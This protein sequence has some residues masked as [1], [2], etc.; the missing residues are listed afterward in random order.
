VNA[1]VLWDIDRTLLTIE[2]VSKDIYAAAFWKVTGQDL[3]D[4]PAMG[5]RT[6]RDLIAAVLAAHGF[7][8]TAQRLDD[9]Y[10]A[11]ASAA[12]DRRDQMLGRGRVLPGAAE[13]LAAVAGVGGVVQ[14][15]VTGNVRSIAELKLSLFK[16]DRYL[17]LD[18]GGYGSDDSD[19]VTLVRLA[20]GR[21]SRKYGAPAADG[22]VVVVGDTTHDIAGAL[23]NGLRAVGVTSGEVPGADLEA[24]GA[25][26]VLPSLADTDAVLRAVFGHDQATWPGR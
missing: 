22:C 24:A 15:V 23:G 8:V 21:A 20:C 14:S 5:G 11:L 25:A 17:D 7:E 6:D 1:L 19:R 12:E 13:A 9:F 18:V 26:V 2:G 4:M 16:L 10:V 3:E